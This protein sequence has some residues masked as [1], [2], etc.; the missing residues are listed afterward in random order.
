[1]AFIIKN[2]KTH[3]KGI[4]IFTHKE[5]NYLIGRDLKLKNYIFNPHRYFID[6]FE[7]FLYKNKMN[8]LINNFKSKYYIGVHWGFYHENVTTENWVDFHMAAKGTVNFDDTTFTI[9]LSSA[10][11]I[12]SN[13]HFD[14]NSRKFW[15][16]VCISR[17]A[18]FKKLDKLL[19]VIRKI[20]DKG[21]LIKICLIVPT[22]KKEGKRSYYT[23]LISD[24]EN[25]FNYEER[26]NFHLIKLDSS[27]GGLGVSNDFISYVYRH[28]KVFTLFSIFEGESRVIKE[29]QKSG[30]LV[31]VNKNL[32]GGGR[33]FLTDENSIQFED[34]DNADLAIKLAID[35]ADEYQ[36]NFINGSFK[37]IDEQESILTLKKY[38]NILYE[39]YNEE[40]DGDLINI[41]NLARRLPGHFKDYN[42]TWMTQK[43]WKNGWSDI[44]NYSMFKRFY[45]YTIN[46]KK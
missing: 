25:M 14:K 43:N 5:Y 6:I 3:Q 7:K 20:Y 19:N 31:V 26:Q 21:H 23:S 10:N 24:Y 33:D 28:S 36:R 46:F 9:P 22:D 35:K 4:I 17:A 37:D 29:A 27:L 32:I 16:L 44:S 18:N 11:F 30:L 38:F 15:D 2:Y 40:F 41:D 1:M 39:K 42:Y 12:N 13:F 45:D 34:Y 8:R